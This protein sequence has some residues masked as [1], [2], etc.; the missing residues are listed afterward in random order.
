LWVAGLLGHP[1]LMR[2]GATT[3]QQNAPRRQVHI[4]KD[5]EP[6]GAARP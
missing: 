5:V 3:G 4:G 2:V 6:F 1:G